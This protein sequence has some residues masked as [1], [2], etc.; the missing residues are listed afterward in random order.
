MIWLTTGIPSRHDPETKWLILVTIRIRCHPDP[1][2]RSPKS[3]YTGLS[4]KFLVDSDQSSIANLHCKNHSAILLCW[5]SAEV[6]ALWVLLVLLPNYYIFFL[7]N[8]LVLQMQNVVSLLRT[9]CLILRTF[10]CMIN[11]SLQS[12][13]SFISIFKLQDLC[14][15][16][17]YNNRSSLMVLTLF[18]MMTILDRTE[19]K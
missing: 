14:W 3:G 1:G 17:Y 6:C 7:F 19:A 9:F 4:K 16:S 12:F 10:T 18:V 8:N 11:P 2:V 13:T 15:K 5:N